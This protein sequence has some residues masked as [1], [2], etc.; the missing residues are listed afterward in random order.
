MRLSLLHPDPARGRTLVRTDVEAQSGTSVATLRPLLARLTGHTGWVDARG[1]VCVDEV[2]LADDHLVGQPPL[3]DGCVLRAEPGPPSVTQA[4][5][6]ADAHVAVTAGPDCGGVLALP[7]GATVRV[8]WPGPIGSPL[9]DL[10]VADPTMGHVELRHRRGRVHVRAAGGHRWW[11]RRTGTPWQVGA[12]TME[13][14]RRGAEEGRQQEPREEQRAPAVAGWL[15]PLVGSVTLAAVLHQ[16]LLA[17][18]GVVG[19]ALAVAP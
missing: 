11:L 13:V 9:V 4:A 12:T 19:A 15:T 14:R 8:G 1:C 17:L 18:V 3:V 7:P 5:L 2:P 6:R 16:P 10:P